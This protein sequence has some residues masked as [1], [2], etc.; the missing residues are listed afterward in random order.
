VLII[1]RRPGER[2]MLGDDI[3]IHVMEIVGSSVRIGIEAPK[4]LPIYREELWAAIKEENQAAASAQP[5]RM[6][7]PAVDAGAR[8]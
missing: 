1:T 6:P 8:V 7:S 5:E 4:A 2:I 3:T